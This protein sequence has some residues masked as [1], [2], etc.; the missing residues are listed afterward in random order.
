MDGCTIL[1]D[2]EAGAFIHVLGRSDNLRDFIGYGTVFLGSLDLD[3]V[4]TS[5]VVSLSSLSARGEIATD[6][7]RYLSIFLSTEEDFV[8]GDVFSYEEDDE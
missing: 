1:S 7:M 3:V 2:D 5:D 4:A 6:Q 8:I